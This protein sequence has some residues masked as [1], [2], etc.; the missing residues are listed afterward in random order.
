MRITRVAESYW[1]QITNINSSQTSMFPVEVLPGVAHY[2]FAGG[3]PPEFVQ[4]NDLRGDVSDEDAHS[5]IGA[6]MTNFIDDILK[7]GSSLSS[8]MTGDYMTPFLEAMYQEGSSVMKEPCYQSD[9]VNVPTP[10]CIKGSP[11]IQERALKTL[12]GNLSDPQVTLVNDDN[13]HRASTVYPY[14]HP[15]LSGDCADHSGPCTVKHISVTQNEYDKLNELDL[16]KTPIGA[17]SMRVKL[18]SSQSIHWQAREPDADFNA[19]DRKL[20]EC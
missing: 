4:K 20:T 19:L 5:L 6:T 11:W 3:V 1:H 2:Q 13:F 16:G 15:E 17:T 14:H 12:V 7:N 8:T 18:K 9:I 10:S